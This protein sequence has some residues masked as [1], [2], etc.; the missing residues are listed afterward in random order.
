MVTVTAMPPHL[1]RAEPPARIRCRPEPAAGPEC[2]ISVRFFV[3]GRLLLGV[4]LLSASG[5][6]PTGPPSPPKPPTLPPL[7]ELTGATDGLVALPWTRQDLA[8]DA[9]IGTVLIPDGDC[10]DIKGVRIRPGPADIELT[11]L[12]TTEPGCTSRVF[13][14]VAIRLPEPLGTRTLRPGPA[15]SR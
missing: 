4:L 5:C 1:V 11:V 12:G 10:H 8:P 7:P 2:L 9:T 13:T 6:T 15:T 3:T 14:V